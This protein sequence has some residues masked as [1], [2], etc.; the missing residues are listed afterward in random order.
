[1]DSHAEGY[2]AQAFSNYTHAEGYNTTAGNDTPTGG[3]CAH[4]EGNGTTASGQHSHAEG[5]NST[6][7]GTNAHAE[8]QSTNAVGTNAHAEGWGTKALGV[9][10]HASG[11]SANVPDDYAFAWNGNDN[12]AVY[13]SHGIGTFNINPKNSLSGFYIGNDNFIQC[14]LSAVQ[15]MDE[16][17]KVALKAALGL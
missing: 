15:A 2:K 6:A 5:L 7:V 14:V 8:G 11:L 12:K 1:M 3:Y 13:T 17:Q 9:A 10:S 16:T 4:A